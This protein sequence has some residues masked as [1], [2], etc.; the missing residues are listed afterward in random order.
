MPKLTLEY[1]TFEEREDYETALNGWKYRII[2]WD[3][4][5]TLRAIVKYGAA[6][7]KTYDEKQC[8]LIDELRDELWELLNERHIEL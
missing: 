7:G 3:F 5:Q 2:L 1:D 4:D 6:N 8:A